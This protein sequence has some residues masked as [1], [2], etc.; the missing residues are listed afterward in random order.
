M[1]IRP[2]TA[3][4]IFKIKYVRFACCKQG[5]W[6]WCWLISDVMGIHEA[7][8][9]VCLLSVVLCVWCLIQTHVSHT[10]TPTTCIVYVSVF[11]YVVSVLLCHTYTVTCILYFALFWSC[12]PPHMA[13][14]CAHAQHILTIPLPRC[15]CCL[16]QI[17]S[18]TP[19]MM[20]CI[21]ALNTCRHHILACLS[22]L[23]FFLFSLSLTVPLYFS[24]QHQ[25]MWSASVE[26]TVCLCMCIGSA[27]IWWKKT[28]EM[29]WCDGMGCDV[30]W[31]DV[32][33]CGVMV[34]MYSTRMFLLL[35]FV[36]CDVRMT[37]VY[38]ANVCVFVCIVGRCMGVC[39]RMK[40]P[41][42]KLHFMDMW[43][44]SL[45]WS[46]PTPAWMLK[47]NM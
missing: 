41:F 11:I 45:R 17:S 35:C 18:S 16:C 43:S 8:D 15:C 29:I 32:M 14:I 7:N 10:N 46:R 3:W 6:C 13:H 20:C 4:C 5:H 38:F 19:Q 33:W 1:N 25:C 42:I 26:C 21:S 47:T 27:S 34:S 37:R 44:V 22:S 23:F 40:R 9:S 2:L 12:V 24:L 30:M 39:C 31:C 28:D 36:M